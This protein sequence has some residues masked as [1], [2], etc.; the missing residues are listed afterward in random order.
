M[1]DFNSYI[2]TAPIDL[3]RFKELSTKLPE[4]EGEERQAIASELI[5]LL[6][7]ESWRVAGQLIIAHLDTSGKKE[8]N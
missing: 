2:K 1:V 4:S 8:E 7:R 3:E 6:K 5:N